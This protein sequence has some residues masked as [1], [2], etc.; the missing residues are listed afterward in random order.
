[1]VSVTLKNLTKRF[2][3]VTA[4]KHMNLQVNDGEFVVLL[5]PSGSGKTTV[6]RSIAG[7]EMPT[8]G[9]VYL[10]GENIT[11]VHPKDRRMSMVF[12]S[13]ALY[14]H[15]TV[16]DNIA[17]PLKMQKLPKE[18]IRKRV[19]E[20]AELL[21]IGHLLKRKPK[22]LSG[23]ERQRVALGR[24]IVKRPVVFLMDEPLSNI[25]AKLRVQLRSELKTLQ[26][27][28]GI[29]T[30]YVTHD[31]VEAMTIADKIAVMDK[32][33]LQQVSPQDEL[34]R[35]PLTSFVA[36]FIGS[37]SMNLMDCIL[38]EKN[39]KIFL[40]VSAFSIN[41]S[42]LAGDLQT[43]VTNSELV[44]GIRP[45]DIRLLQGEVKRKPDFIASVHTIEPLGMEKI[46][47]LKTEDK[48]LRTN[49]RGNLRINVGDEIGVVFD[50]Q[51]LYIFDRKT[52][53][54]FL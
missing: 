31:Q 36:S 4:V 17:F 20:T 51:K 30:I 34:Y 7:L 24:A 9:R 6:L 26:R 44:L 1:M 21:K 32:G 10:N 54:R 3:D 49:V 50:K 48:F 37:P 46:V 12:Q 15:M 52:G 18:E 19:K 40:D 35:N 42:E 2:G 13:Y 23:G 25:D 14:P 47:I 5:G 41:V 8:E 53:K 45:E 27:N 16:Y 28:L 22:E 29:T 39:G 33:E 38:V 11:Y 43:R